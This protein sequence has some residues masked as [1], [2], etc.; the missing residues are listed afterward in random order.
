MYIPE[1]SKKTCECQRRFSLVPREIS[2]L[3]QT[4]DTS[5]PNCVPG[6]YLA[7]LPRTCQAAF[8]R[9]LGHSWGFTPETYY[10]DDCVV[11]EVDGEP[12][13]RSGYLYV[14]TPA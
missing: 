8:E 12:I 13:V 6:L 14:R 9:A 1:T 5:C 3:L 4:G 7:D 2:S 10:D 11:G